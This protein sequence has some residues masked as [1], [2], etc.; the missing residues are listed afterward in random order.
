LSRVVFGF[1]CVIHDPIEVIKVGG[2]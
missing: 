2:I 1:I